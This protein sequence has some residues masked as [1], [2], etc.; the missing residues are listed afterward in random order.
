MSKVI[1]MEE[2]MDI[3]EPNS[4]IMT[5]GFLAAAAPLKVIDALAETDKTG[6]T[7][8]S[9]VSA[10]PGVKH[11]LGKLAANNQ[12]KKMITAHIGTSKEI[13]Q[14]YLS[15]EL[16]VEFIPMGTWNECVHAAG[17]GLG[18]VLT[19]VGVGTMQEDNHEK[20]T[21]NGKDFLLYEPIG[22]DFS[23]LKG[24]VVD[25]HGNVK[26]IGTSKSNVLQVALA[27]KTVIVEAE[28]I[29]ECGEIDP[30][31]VE[32]PGP[33]VDYVVKG[34]DRDENVEHFVEIWDKTGV[35]RKG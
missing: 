31:E 2:L 29:V 25:T 35:L 22:A 21:I 1:S 4:S 6:F 5:S 33:L 9:Q 16:E 14:K 12:M 24:G 28:E 20:I 17:A 26:V 18:G 23:I 7:V 11:D 10:I 27:G 15:G 34:Y 30:F 19:P 32:V 3:I 8:I 13:S